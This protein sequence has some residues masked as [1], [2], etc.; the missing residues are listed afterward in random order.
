M[1]KSLA[2]VLALIMVLSS[3]SFVSAAP[4]FADVKGTKYEDAVARLELL[5]V[6]KGY[7][8][9]SFKPENTITRAEFAAVAVRAKGLAG[10]AEAAKGLPS[11]FS[12]VPAGHWAAGY[13][14][15]AGS[16]GIVNGIGGGLF[17]PNAPVKYEEAVTMLVRALGYEVS[18]QAKGGYPFGYLIVA[19]EIDLLDDV[20]GTMGV[21]ATRGMVAMLTDNALE[22]PMMVQVGFGTDTKWV[23]SGTG[24]S[25]E[26]VFLLDFMGF[27]AYEG[28]VKKIDVSK[29][30]VE[31]DGKD[32][33]MNGWYNA[34]AGFD[35]FTTHMANVKVWLDGDDIVVYTLKDKVY[36]DAFEVDGDEI[37][38]V[39]ADVSFDLGKAAPTADAE[40]AKI[41]VNKDGEVDYIEV[42]DLDGFILVDKVDDEIIVDLNDD[43]LDVEDFAIVK[44]GKSVQVSDLEKGDL[45]FF[46]DGDILGGEFEGLAIAFNNSKTG[47]IDRVYSDSFRFGGKNYT[48]DA[49]YAMY[50][51]GTDLDGLTMDIIEG[52][53]DEESEVE[54]FFNFNGDVALVAGETGNVTTSSFYAVVTEETSTWTTRSGKMWSLDV[55]TEKGEEVAYD[56]K[57]TDI[58]ATTSPDDFFKG[59]WDETTILEGVL[60]K[61]TVDEDGEVTKVE[62]L[63]THAVTAAFDIEDSYAKVGDVSYR[64]QASTVV[65]YDYDDGAPEKV[66]AFGDVD[67]EF[68]EIEV[69]DIYHADGRVKVILATE[70]DADTEATSVTGLLTNVRWLRT[71]YVEFTME[72]AG[73]EKVYL[74]EG[75]VTAQS[76]FDAYKALEDGIVKVSVGDVSGKLVKFG[77]TPAYA[78]LVA[79]KTGTFSVVSRSTVDKTILVYN[80]GV[81]NFT[82][83]LLSNTVIYDKDFDIVNLR[84]LAA[85]DGMFIYMDGASQRFVKYIILKVAK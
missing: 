47:K 35:Y 56:L 44:G 28:L 27:K 45:V 18:A 74:T 70:T 9:G 60:V 49:T 46:I 32:S 50:L 33:D 39:T 83:E 10:V 7:P 13:V 77:T 61:I 68:Y 48:F 31:I 6:L 4:D 34:P 8:D 52:M 17:A 2:L 78:E 15:V 66:I 80:Q 26:E 12:D 29:S 67:D 3:F 82:I 1:K 21:P 69:A 54:I 63:T 16:T 5:N 53:Y 72:V 41:V 64:L 81:G 57:D 85:N 42:L 73:V 43:E 55:L 38:L 25:E 30:K 58:N 65:F 79:P 71:E 22:I 36:F 76:E 11:G 19:K 84:D 40:F 59:T 24:D 51:D 37:D 20:V 62:K 14:G 75:K 23:V